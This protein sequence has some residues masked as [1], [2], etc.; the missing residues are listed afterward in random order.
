MWLAGSEKSKAPSPEAEAA[1]GERSG[2]LPTAAAAESSENYR[3]G[4]VGFWR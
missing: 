1:V 2:D 4:Y 3:R